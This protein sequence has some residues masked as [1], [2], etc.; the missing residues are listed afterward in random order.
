MFK[1]ILIANRGEIAVRVIRAC[2]ELGIATVAVYS[3]VDRAS[4]HVRVADE[5]YCIGPAPASQ[6][7]LNA[8]KIIEVA[9][10]AKVDAIHPGYG[11]LSENANFVELCINNNIVFIGPNPQAIR[12]MSNKIT[13]RV[14]VAR[15]N[16]PLVPGM[17][18]NLHDEK[19]CLEWADKIGYPLMLK[20]AA[21]GGGKGMCKVEGPNELLDAFRF[22]K[23]EASKFF[24]DDAVYMER[25]IEN[26]RHIEIQ[27]L[28]DRYGSIIH[29]GERE[30][31]IQRRH[32]KIIEE[33]PSPIVDG[34]MRQRMGE[35]A[36]NVAR[37]VNYDSV[38]TVEFIVSGTSKEFFFLEMHTC[39]QV[40]HPVTEM[41]TGIDLCKEMIHVAAGQELT[42][43]QQDVQIR[44][45]AIECRIF[46]EDPDNNFLPTPGKIV[47]LR[48]P[49]GPGVRDESG[50][51][52]GFEVPID[53]D[54][55]ISK[56]VVVG[57]DRKDA[58]ARCRRA[59]SEYLVKGIKTTIPFHARVMLDEHF[60]SGDFDTNYID[61]SFN[62]KEAE[63]ERPYE[64]VAIIGAAIKAFRLNQKNSRRT[65]SANEDSGR[66]NPWK[67]SGRIR[68]LNNR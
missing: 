22:T 30:C 59:L 44:G 52:S 14:A 19:H 66:R 27:V 20:A 18:E 60:I 47:G 50:M 68:S 10:I 8:E 63:R 25:Y 6:S 9:K 28:G 62:I 16:V 34:K 53:Y 33:A 2:K 5:A 3:E 55:L 46:A 48:I 54:P 67:L 51:Y 13:S 37:T 21:G 43:K 12:I 36:L 45:H 65:M 7:Y 42:I 38:G 39:L 15:R 41:V 57:R 4:L 11:F 49:G 31:S 29:V 32:Q 24:N 40:E 58:I 23:S 56:L 64:N 35:A 61:S 17:K 26:P 1:K